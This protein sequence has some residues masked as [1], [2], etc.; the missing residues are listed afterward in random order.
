[1][2]SEAFDFDPVKAWVSSDS[3]FTRLSFASKR[4]LWKSRSNSPLNS[5]KANNIVTIYWIAFAIGR[6]SGIILTPFITSWLY[7]II[8][9]AGSILSV[10]AII[11]LDYLLADDASEAAKEASLITNVVIFAIFV[12][13]IYGCA[14]NFSNEFTNMSLSYIYL[15]QARVDKTDFLRS[16]IFCPVN[17]NQ[18]W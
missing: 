6:L 11:A 1:M 5:D 2:C 16:V 14:T 17:P 7:I 4:T 15:T 3:G 10:A 8:D 9:C 13:C 18:S 12:S